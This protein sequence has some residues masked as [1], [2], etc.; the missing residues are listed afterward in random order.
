MPAGGGNGS[1]IG[2]ASVSIDADGEIASAGDWS[3]L[4]TSTDW[5]ESQPVRRMEL[6]GLVPEAG[7]SR[8]TGPGQTN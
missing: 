1:D 5:A 8:T 6:Y 4:T 2:L 7:Q 3:L